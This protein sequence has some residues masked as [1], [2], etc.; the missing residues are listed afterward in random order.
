LEDYIDSSGTIPS[1]ILQ[2]RF[3]LT[4][5]ELPLPTYDKPIIF[6]EWYNEA[7]T[8]EKTLRLYRAQ[9]GY[10]LWKDYVRH[11]P[12]PTPLINPYQWLDNY[13]KL[14]HIS[15]HLWFNSEGISTNKN[16]NQS[17]RSASQNN[18]HLHEVH[19]N[20]PS[21]LP[22]IHKTGVFTLSPSIPC[23][24]KLHMTPSTFI[25]YLGPKKI[26]SLLM[27][28]LDECWILVPLV[29]Q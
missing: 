4:K 1:D 21:T 16:P 23:P 10:K 25:Q 8:A 6:D 12:H 24:L 20:S 2:S 15:N 17:S 5:L 3:N 29:Q 9:L 27:E 7:T 14:G 26:M 13:N 22:P 18:P 28:T 11:N 19:A